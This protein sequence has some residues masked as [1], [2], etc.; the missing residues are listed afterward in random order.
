[1]GTYRD[2]HEAI[3]FIEEQTRDINPRLKEWDDAHIHR[4]DVYYEDAGG[5]FGDYSYWIKEREVRNA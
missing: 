1:M 5:R 4:C 3:A 2:L